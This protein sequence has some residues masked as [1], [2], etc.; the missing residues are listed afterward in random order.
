MCYAIPGKVRSI[1][2]KN[3]IV[4]Y[5]GE[6]K[7]AYNELHDVKIGD[8]IYAQGGFVINV[9]PEKEALQVLQDWKDVFFALQRTDKRLSQL[10]MNTTGMRKEIARILDKAA[11][12]RILS[13]E[14]LIQLMNIEDKKELNMMFKVA[15]FLRQKHL[16]NSA[17]V[18]G[19]IEISNYC[20]ND[21]SYCG[22]RA[23]ANVKRYRMTDEEIYAA[24]DEAI[25]KHGFKVL[26]LQSGED[27][28]F[29][30]ERL[31][32]IIKTIKERH[33]LLLFIS[34]GELG[35]DGL[36]RLYNAGARGLLLRFETSDPELYSKLHCGDK[37]EDRIQDIKDAYAMGY[38]ILTGGLVG[39][40]GQTRE[41]LVNDVILTHDLHAEMFSFGPVLPNGPKVEEMLKVI[42]ISRLVDPANSRILITTGFETLDANAP[43]LGLMAGGNSMMLNATPI[44]Y[45]KLYDIYPDR[46]HVDEDIDHQISWALKLLQDLGRAPTDLGHS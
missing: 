42:A 41:S 1:N 38:L 14:E 40:P 46:A 10:D 37:L 44:K 27:P 26:L 8:Y 39:L 19:I 2:G 32:K 31:E 36:K 35:K 12:D 25:T 9:V 24:A 17:C 6:E 29:T 21:C 23:S 15:N 5:F 33:P 16:K 22:I 13:K 43:T 4:D 18:H 20:K 34:F 7:K 28:E 3:I 11:E 45:R 30:I